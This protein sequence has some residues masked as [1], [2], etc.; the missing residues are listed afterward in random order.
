MKGADQL[1]YELFNDQSY[2][3]AAGAN[4]GHDGRRQTRP[5]RPDLLH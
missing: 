3:C 1:R 4:H 5:L 2:S